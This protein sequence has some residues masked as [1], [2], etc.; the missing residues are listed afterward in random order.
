[1]TGRIRLLLALFALAFAALFMRGAWIQ[2]VQAGRLSKLAHSQHQ[3]SYT[4]PAAA[5]RYL[6]IYG[7]HAADTPAKVGLAAE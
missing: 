7:R 6:A 3:K 2:G 1:M 5:K 4:I